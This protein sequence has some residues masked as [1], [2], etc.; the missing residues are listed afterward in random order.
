MGQFLPFLWGYLI[1][2]RYPFL[3]NPLKVTLA[4]VSLL[5]ESQNL[6]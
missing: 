6:K 3:M 4:G 2:D 1:E 5:T